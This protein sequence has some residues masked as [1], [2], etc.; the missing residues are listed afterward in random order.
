MNQSGTRIPNDSVTEKGPKGKSYAF[1]ADTL[2]DESLVPFIDGCDLLY[3]E[4]TYLKDLAEKAASRFHS[5]T[6][7]AASFAKKG[8]V[9]RL[10]IGHFSSKYEKLEQFELESRE[11]FPETD[12]ALEG[13]TYIL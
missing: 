8:N 11:V 4:T 3:H 5:T 12:L 1:C 10:L 13:T 7:Q 6:I 2:Y 9:N